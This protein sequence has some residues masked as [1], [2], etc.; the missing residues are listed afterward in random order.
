MVSPFTYATASY[1]LRKNKSFKTLIAN[2]RKLTVVTNANSAI[3]DK[4]MGSSFKDFED[5]LQFYSAID[6]HA[7]RIVTRNVKDFKEATIP[8]DSPSD[9]IQFFNDKAEE[10]N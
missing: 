2:F 10:D 6:S 3:I 7:D 1:L 4:A 5:A 9:F 8:V